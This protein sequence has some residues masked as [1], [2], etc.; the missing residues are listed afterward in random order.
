MAEPYKI[1]TLHD[2][3]TMAV[4]YVGF[5]SKTLEKRLA[6]HVAAS[7]NE[8]NHR[9]NWIRSLVSV[10][11]RP[12]ILLVEGVSLENWQERER[13]WI[14]HFRSI[15]CS[16]V[17]SCE[18]G[19]GI[20]GPSN[21][22]REKMSLANLGRKH[23]EETCLKMS[24]AKIGKN[25][26]LE[27]RRKIGLANIGKNHTEEARAKM[28]ASKLGK[29]P[30]RKAIANSCE[31]NRKPVVEIATGRIFKSIAS[32]AIEFRVTR[33]SISYWIRRGKFAYA[34][35]QPKEVITS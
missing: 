8:R 28:S 34:N 1:Y 12:A 4:R 5:T 7:K 25:F 18:G 22:V 32:A 13:F 20:I 19:K 16:L 2:P 31:T 23:T 10:G 26:T 11:K 24:R 29:K 9:A 30:S 6:R 33:Q 3:D 27:H 15:G 21:E 17:N 35:N 14:L